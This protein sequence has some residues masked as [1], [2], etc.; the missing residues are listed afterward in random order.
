MF[1][2]MLLVVFGFL[3][4]DIA[5]HFLWPALLPVLHY[6]ADVVEP[7]LVVATVIVAFAFV[8]FG[9]FSIIVSAFVEFCREGWDSA[10]YQEFRRHA[11]R[12]WL[13]WL[14]RRRQAKR[15]ALASAKWEQ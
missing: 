8:A 9:V 10:D 3:F 1:F 14:V 2:S 13:R 7:A 11:R 4:A 15:L 12:S 5:I 6:R